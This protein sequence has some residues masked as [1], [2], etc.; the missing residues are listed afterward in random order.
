MSRIV[1]LSLIVAC[2]FL[3]SC[4]SRKEPAPQAEIVVISKPAEVPPGV[5]AMCW[6]EPI[7]KVET[8]APGIDDEGKWYHPYYK[9]V[10][11]VRQ[12]RWRPCSEVVSET[13]EGG[14]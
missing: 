1:K 13:R 5:V 11:E 8:Q 14:K 12:G 7:V 4:S 9:K 6:E 2:L 10:R 3:I